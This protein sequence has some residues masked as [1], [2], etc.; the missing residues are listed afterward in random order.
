MF[1]SYISIS[2][3]CAFMLVST[4]GLAVYRIIRRILLNKIGYYWGGAISISFLLICNTLFNLLVSVLMVDSGTLTNPKTI[5]NYISVLYLIFLCLIWFAIHSIIFA[6][7]PNEIQVLKK[8]ILD[9]ENP[10]LGVQTLLNKYPEMLK[11]SN[12]DFF[13]NYGHILASFSILFST[14]GVEI[15]AITVFSSDKYPNSAVY[16]SGFYIIAIPCF[17]FIGTLFSAS[18]LN[19]NDKYCIGLL[20]FTAI[21]TIFI[22]WISFYFYLDNDFYYLG[23][24]IA[25]ILYWLSLTMIYNYNK[26]SYQYFSAIC[27]LIAVI[28]LGLMWPLYSAGGMK[29][30]TFWIVCGALLFGG[31]F[32]LA[33]WLSQF[34]FRLSK[35]L[36]LLI[37]EV[38]KFNGYDLAQYLYSMSFILGFC[39]LGFFTFKRLDYNNDWIGGFVP[40]CFTIFGFMIF[41]TVFIHRIT[42]YVSEVGVEEASIRDIIL[43]SVPPSTTLQVEYVRKKK[44]I[45]GIIG[46]FGIVI[47][48]AIAIPVL[49]TSSEDSSIAA[50]ITVIVGLILAILILIVFIELKS[51]LRQFGEI[52][53]SYTLGCCWLFFLIPIVCLIPVS[54]SSSQSNNDIHSIT[55]WSVG[56]IL[57]I[58]MVG[59]SAGSITLNLLFRRLEYEKIAK[60][61]CEQVRDRLTENG[62]RIKLVTLRSIYDNFRNSGAE[63]V[64]KVLVNATVYNY[65][66]LDK[67]PDLRYSKEILTLKEISKLRS[68]K[69][70]PV[71]DNQHQESKKGTTLIQFIKK[72]CATQ[73]EIQSVHVSEDL[74]PEELIGI[75]MPETMIGNKIL[76]INDTIED[77][78]WDQKFKENAERQHDFS[79]NIRNSLIIDEELDI[80][81]EELE[82]NLEEI[83]EVNIK[84]QTLQELMSCKHLEIL[85]SSEQIKNKWLR[86]VFSRFSNGFIEKSGTPWMNLSDLR[87]FIRLSGM[88]PYISYAASDILY[89]R[90]TRIYDPSTMTKTLVKLDFEQFSEVLLKQLGKLRYPH[91]SYEEAQNK[92]FSELIYP[93]LVSNLP[94]L[95]KYYPSEVSIHD[96]NNIDYIQ[97]HGENQSNNHSFNKNY[98]DEKNKDDQGQFSDPRAEH[99]IYNMMS[100]DP[101]NINSPRPQFYIEGRTTKRFDEPKKFLCEKYV[102][103][104]SRCIGRCMKG[105]LGC[106]GKGFGLCLYCLMPTSKSAEEV[107]TKEKPKKEDEIFERRRSPS[108]EVI[109]NLIVTTFSLADAEAR[110]D[111]NE[112]H[113]EM[114]FNLS[115]IIGIFGHVTEIY[116]F[117]SVGFLKQ[118]GWIYGSNFTRASTAVLA[119]NDYWVETYWICFSC[120][121]IFVFLVIP[122]IKYI[123][124]GRLGLNSDFTVASFPSPQF[125]LSKFIALF[126]KTMYLTILSAMLSSFSCVYENNNWHL[127]RDSSIECFSNDHGVYF[128]LAILSLLLYYP[129]ATLLFPNIAFQDKALDI[130][131]DTTYLVLE[132]QGKVVIAAVAAFFAKE[133]YIWLQLIV[134]I[135]VSG[136]LFILNLRM[137]PCLIMSYNLWKTGG[138]FVPVWI[139]SCGLLNYYSG[140]NILAMSLLVIG[141]GVIL[142]VL[143]ALQGKLYGFRC[144]SRLKHVGTLVSGKEVVDDPNDSGKKQDD[145]SRADINVTNQIIVNEIS[146]A[147]A[148]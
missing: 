8:E 47:T 31:A 61:C 118:V 54:L 65:H 112:K 69:N 135:C 37:K 127:M 103:G 141:L 138:F 55:S 114:Q 133:K 5:V 137:K 9:L 7:Y 64:E 136:I 12:P 43:T 11:N 125:F 35:E 111:S 84:P 89:V 48:C 46:A 132:S 66:E 50:G 29:T 119:D 142:G 116:S 97:L 144:F 87:H 110:K 38:R 72:L 71:I 39:L 78:N 22:M 126:G 77:R 80:P 131:F 23:I 27:C 18:V 90:L 96:S 21:P 36:V 52:V 117:S 25:T 32:I 147:K 128:A 51:V 108:W 109:C 95:Y 122:A 145:Q 49:V 94:Y 28:P 115:N 41:G 146:E 53:I 4:T 79:N 62:V 143:L 68:S 92:I 20:I 2:V 104:F 3:A 73:D 86:A 17:I 82:K 88:K 33:L 57:L 148:E 56:S 24:L 16:I 63:S 129:F 40:G 85:N 6:R 107:A 15:G 124:Q 45:Q 76:D 130:K 113:P 99:S 13:S 139:C 91:L 101:N 98:N 30:I 1:I 19:K 26:R 106:M 123:K 10:S 42:L 67:D 60:Y 120:S 105:I 140:Q 93:N 83:S 34:V 14:I 100:F 102:D 58:F 70:I 134:S 121:M 59:V 44:K 75:D 74:K 81:R